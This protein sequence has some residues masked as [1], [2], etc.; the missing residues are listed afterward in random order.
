MQTYIELSSAL[1]FAGFFFTGVLA[2]DGLRSKASSIDLNRYKLESFLMTTEHENINQ[3]I[4]SSIFDA[5]CHIREHMADIIGEKKLDS[6]RGSLLKQLEAEQNYFTVSSIIEALGKIG[7]YNDIQS[8]LNWLDKHQDKI[9]MEHQYFLLKHIYKALCQ[10]DTTQNQE[11]VSSFYNK[12]A[13]YMN[14]YI[15]N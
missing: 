2:I 3:I 15:V 8:I 10:L 12:Y 4:I 6:A 1:L 7:Y 14:D 9:I 5:N 13:V 11:Y